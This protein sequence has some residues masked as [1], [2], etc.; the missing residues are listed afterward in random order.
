MSSIIAVGVGVNTQVMRN[1]HGA[2]IAGRFIKNPP[3]QLCCYGGF[4]ENAAHSLY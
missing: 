2:S 1:K 3:E 4:R